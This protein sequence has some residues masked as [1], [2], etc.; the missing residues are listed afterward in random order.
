[1]F[2][3]VEILDSS[4]LCLSLL[5]VVS[6]TVQIALLIWVISGETEGQFLFQL[7]IRC[8]FNNFYLIVRALEI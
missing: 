5:D 6:H 8:I 2:E 3:K 4:F 7:G 1:M